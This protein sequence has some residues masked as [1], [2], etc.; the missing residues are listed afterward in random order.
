MKKNNRISLFLSDVD[1]SLTTPDHQVT[2]RA[3][4][5][6]AT[7]KKQGIQFS[8]VSGRPP[9]GMRELI[10][11]LELTL[12]L[13]AFDGGM[14]IRPDLSIIEEHLLDGLTAAA[15]IKTVQAEGVDVWLYRGTDWFVKGGETAHV[16]HET[17]NVGFE[18][19]IVPE[20][21]TGL[22]A[23]KIVAVSDDADRLARCEKAIRDTFADTVSAQ[24]SQSFYLDITHP[25][26]NKGEVVRALS[27]LLSIPSNEFVTLGDMSNDISMFKESGLSIAMGNAS[28]EVNEAADYETK[29]NDD[30]GFA[31]AIEEIIM[32]L[33][34]GESQRS[35]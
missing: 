2:P 20:I 9:K 6:L 22:G 27:K 1:G 33:A 34:R 7:L 12:P 16:L 26:A 21:D 32:S 17:A 3:R 23:V 15:V 8:I 19:L 24:L 4:L 10:S 14:I 28:L 25:K 35:A 5:A 13:A 18:P 29:R 30:E 31:Y 11:E